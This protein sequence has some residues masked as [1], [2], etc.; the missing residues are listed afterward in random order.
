MTEL[1]ISKT[2]IYPLKLA[3][4]LKERHNKELL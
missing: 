1:I 3:D 4:D 2:I